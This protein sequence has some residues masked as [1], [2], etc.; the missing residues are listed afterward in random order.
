MLVRSL[1]AFSTGTI[2]MYNGEIRTIDD[3]TATALI[4]D[5]CVVEYTEPI[6][7]TG[8]KSIIANGTYDV[9]EKAS[10][11]V[12]VPNPSTGSLSVTAN[13]TYDVTEKA[14]VDVN[15][16][17]VTITYDVN[18]GTGTISAVT[19]IAGN[20][21]ELNDGTGITAPEGKQFAG[22]A[23]TNDAENPDVTSPYTATANVTLY[24][25]YEAVNAE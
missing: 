6:V 11:V 25:V 21:V 18:G 1:K 12:N 7:P 13:G 9:T 23:T 2:S 20:T 3:T 19:A 15:V 10:A 4:A 14:S 17:V 22:W 16:S 24:A 5:N 8:E